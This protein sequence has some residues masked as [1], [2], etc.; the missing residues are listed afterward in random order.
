MTVIRGPFFLGLILSAT[1]L[2]ETDLAIL[3]EEHQQ[4]IAT[5]D[6]KA[7]EMTAVQAFWGDAAFM[8][9]CVPADAELP[10][11]LTIFFEV[12]SNGALGELVIAPQNEVARCISEAV[13]QRR[14][15]V[16]PHRWIGKIELSFTK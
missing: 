4:S 8:R 6:G 9:E 12:E 7:F 13:S 5:A 11:P 16:P 3:E 10:E 2:A 15:P 1:C 14:F